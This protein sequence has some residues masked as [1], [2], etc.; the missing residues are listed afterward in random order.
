MLEVDNA[1]SIRK[2]GKHGK[3]GCTGSAGRTLLF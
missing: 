2:V 1:T 3:E